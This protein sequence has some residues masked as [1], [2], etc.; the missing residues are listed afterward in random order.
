GDGRTPAGIF[1]A[2]SPF[3]F[4]DAP[5]RDYV[6]L[7]PGT[8]CVDDLDSGFYN[9][10]VRLSSVPDGLSHEKMWEVP[11]YRH[12]VVIENATS[13]QS[14][15]GSC[16]FLHVWRAPGS[17]T[18]GCVAAAEGNVVR[19]QELFDAEDAA[20]AI[21]PR[22]SLEAISGCGLPGLDGLGG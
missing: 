21:L 9:R 1:S 4:A 13:R 15:G 14:R 6:T 10:V 12:G 11:L 8:I 2:G 18:S 3:G 22:V 19:A 7:T 16:I 5:L 20:V 17:P